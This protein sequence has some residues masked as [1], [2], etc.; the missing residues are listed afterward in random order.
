MKPRNY[1]AKHNPHRA[2]AFRDKKKQAKAGYRKH[3]PNWP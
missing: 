3:K 2:Q 1:V